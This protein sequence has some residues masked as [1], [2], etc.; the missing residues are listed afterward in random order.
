MIYNGID[1]DI[2]SKEKRVKNNKSYKKVVIPCTL[3]KLREQF[4][5]YWIKRSSQFERVLIYGVNCGAD[6]Q[7]NMFAKILPPVSDVSEII[8][9]ADYVAGI[10]M[11]RVNLEAMSMG[12]P[13]YIHDP[14]NPEKF[15]VFDIKED[16]FDRKFNIKNVYKKITELL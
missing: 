8:K 15:E 2:F 14:E 11:G 12:I 1:R 3:D 5:N 13:S 6:L 4:L 10:L 16:S 9:D 7:R